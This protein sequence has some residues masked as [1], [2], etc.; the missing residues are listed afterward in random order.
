MYATFA[1]T[2]LM[3]QP[4]SHELLDSVWE[5]PLFEALY[6]RRSRR[7]GLGFEMPQGPF[8]Y[9]SAH[10]PLPLTETEEA[11]LV[12]AGAGF[13]G[14]ALW[15]LAT[16]SPYS[17]LSGRTFPA[18]R[19]GGHT[20]LFFT[21][22]SGLYVLDDKVAASKPKEVETRS[23]RE[24]VVALF[25]EQRRQLRLGRLDVPRRV[26]PYSAHD[27][28]DSNKAGT[29]VFMPVC[30][31]SQA[32]ISLIA[33]FVDPALQRYAPASG[34]WNVV[35]D[36]HGFRP[37]G[38]E[39]WLKDGFLD[40]ARLMPLSVLERQA[41]YYTF[42]EP[43]AISQNMLLAAE[44]LG[45]GG[46]KHCGFLSLEMLQCMGFRIVSSGPASFGNPVG[47]DGIIE[48]HCPPYFAN[49]DQAVDSVLL[50]RQRDEISTAS[51]PHLMPEAQHHSGTVKISDAGI[52]CTKAVCNYI[53]D[54]YGRF[55]GGTDAL[56]LMWIIQAH[57][58]DTDFY[59]RFFAAGA[60]GPTQAN[61][62]VTWHHDVNHNGG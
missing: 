29:T 43:A 13:S 40:A 22:D 20:T 11:L 47:L 60:Y 8:R 32:L 35:D 34:G 61:H 12:A 10:A 36:R 57:H 5:Y 56:H 27:L 55:P 23:E 15:D 37:A 3:T 46:W 33:Q 42:S 18:T 6:G 25:R 14:L 59:D 2:F 16:P 26:P 24:K 21:N 51:R 44:A 28:W 41:C 53:F 50:R 9:K 7:F 62:L 58:I 52:A 17:A 48:A 30:D 54:T 39:Q 1:R 4:T 45:L 19:S 31:V 49:M 38:T